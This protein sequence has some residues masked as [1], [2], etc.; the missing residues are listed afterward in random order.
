MT[1]ISPA[2]IEQ[3]QHEWLTAP[4]KAKTLVVKKWACSLDCSPQ[5]IWGV[6]DTGRK[7]QKG[8]YKTEHLEKHVEIIFQVK[9][10]PPESAGELSTDQATQI[11]VNSG[12]VP[13]EISSI[14]ISTINRV[15]RALRLNQKVRRV[16]RYQAERP[17]QMHHVDASSSQFFYVAR[18]LPDGDH[19]LKLF[20]PSQ[21]Y[22]NKPTPI[23]LRPWIYGITDDYSGYAL[24]RYTA[25]PGEDMRDNLEFLEWAWGKTDDKP[26]FGLPEKIKADKGPMMRGLA[27]Q[28]LFDRL[29]VD[30]DPSVPYAKDAHGKIERPWRTH[31]QRFEK[32]FFAQSDWKKFEITMS[33]LNRQF[34]NYFLNEYN[35]RPHRHERGI[36]RQQAWRKI[37]LYGGAVAMPE[38]AISTTATRKKRKVG[39]DGCIQLEG[40]TYEV[41]GLH[42][43]WVYVI[44]GLFTDEIIVQDIGTGEKHDV[45]G[46]KPNPIDTFTAH[47][48]TPHQKAQKAAKKL[49]MTSTLFN[50]S[51]KM[52]NVVSLPERI[53]EERL[54][55]NL[56]DTGIY[57]S[58]EES[59]R[60]FT[61][62]T[63][64]CVPAGSE[65]R[66][67]LEQLIME[68]K[69]SKSFVRKIADDFLKADNRYEGGIYG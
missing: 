60:N 15:G 47:K 56:F 57:F 31:W 30:V 65:E 10:S 25:A 26:F 22:K 43:A 63:G 7:R 35:Q 50:G 62:F 12:L 51:K 13:K 5:K 27:A 42:D 1:S 54:T 39:A 44:R 32:Q 16:Q 38:D 33:E 21:I 61:I 2:F 14:S 18:A 55:E 23:Q 45:E 66:A 58:L 64:L 19:V 28:E 40:K 34:L 29:G 20:T 48:D 46:F 41:K 6:L 8:N 53:K 67:S 37:N 68:Q 24:A 9:K 11:A 52:T 59:M 49:G 4:K 17:N 69:M 3:I 36:T